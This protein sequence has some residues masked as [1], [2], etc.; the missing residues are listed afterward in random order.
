[1]SAPGVLTIVHVI[2][3]LVIGG[4][5]NGVV[6]LIN[7]L[8]RDRFR[9]VVVCIEDY[10]GFSRRIERSDVEIHALHRSKIGAWRLRWRLFQLFRKLRPDIVHSRN[11]SGLDALLP[12]RLAGIKTLHSEHGFDVDNLRGNA[13]RPALLRR[14]HSPLV[15]RYVAVSKHLRLLMTEHWGISEGQVTQIY[16]GVDTERFC[17]GT[18]SRPELLPPPFQGSSAFIVGTVG[19]AQAVKDQVTLLRAF[20]LVLARRPEWRLRMRLLVVGDGPMLQQLR[21]MA[22]AL[23]IASLSWFAGGRDDVAELLKSMDL[24]VLPSLMEGISNTLLEA[25]STGLPVLATDVG[26]NVEL[27]DEGVAGVSFAAGDSA[28]LSKLIE[29]FADDAKL[30]ASHAKAARAR[31]LANFSLQGMVA[32]Y[33]EIYESL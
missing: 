15:R 1:M 33:Q 30:C 26:G 29:N 28:G 5:E 31:V 7:R 11:L 14:L 18:P 23:D 9:H 22:D 2:H 6:N 13:S 17:P 16:N 20:A 19:R 27:L 25:M 32:N 10:S 3:H 21:T 8:P 24:F 12:A 4:M